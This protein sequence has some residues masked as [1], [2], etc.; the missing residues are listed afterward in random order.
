MKKL[1]T[2]LALIMAF[3]LLL[4][5]TVWAEG[6]SPNAKATTQGMLFLDNENIYAGMDQS[7][8]DGYIPPVEGGR[9]RV[10]LPLIPAV[11]LASQSIIVSPNY[12]D[13]DTSPFAF[14]NVQR[15]VRKGSHQI[16]GTSTNQEAFLVDM[17]FNLIKDPQ[18]GRY[19][20]VLQVSYND[21]T[22][23]VTQDFTVYV[24]I[25]GPASTPT[26][27]PSPDTPESPIPEPPVDGGGS[28]GGGGGGSGTP[29]SQP[30]ILISKYVVN[31]EVVTAGETFTIQLS[32]KNSH[33]KQDVRNVKLTYKSEGTD[34]LPAGDTNILYYPKIKKG[35]VQ[36]AELQL[37]VR[38]DAEPKPQKVLVTLDYEDKNAQ[39]LTVTEEI[40]VEVAQLPRVEYDDPIVP[41]SISAG[42]SQSLSL[43]VFNKGKGQIY[44]VMC[45]V[46]VPGLMPEG[47]AFLGNLEPGGTK[48]AEMVVYAAM[49]DVLPPSGGAGAEPQGDVDTDGESGGEV[50]PQEPQPRAEGDAADEAVP[51]GESGTDDIPPEDDFADPLMGGY[52]PVSGIIR[53]TYEDSFGQVYEDTVDVATVI[54]E[55]YVPNMPTDTEPTEKP[56]GFPWW[57]YATIG[58]GVAAI[59]TG[60][61]LWQRKKRK[62]WMDDEME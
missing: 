58:V 36:E 12:G 51:E 35:A 25:E 19:P 45:Q 41:E 28:I 30:R 13:P 24:T 1:S 10:I 21:G 52:G 7:Y 6:E 56:Q 8:S 27:S 29:D 40:V 59:V 34:I 43:N 15:T 11:G 20:L 3:T 9:V 22:D 57:G 31:P 2:V 14:N 42:D 26:P 38:L 39:A 44:N 55:P 47:S 50:L 61:V 60:I 23:L 32:L 46:E 53:I 62:A 18:P 4:G 48:L 5:S 17:Y 33:E 49:P 37:K 16:N 54:S